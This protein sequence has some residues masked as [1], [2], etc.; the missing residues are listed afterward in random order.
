[1]PGIDGREA[2]RRLRSTPGPN[3]ETPVIAITASATPKDW[4]ACLAAGMNGYVGKPIEPAQLYAVLE[5]VVS[6]QSLEAAA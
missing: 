2:T 6:G 3:R 5:A 4:D 1:M